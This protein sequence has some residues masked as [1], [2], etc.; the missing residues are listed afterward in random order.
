[1]VGEGTVK[2]EQEKTD[3]APHLTPT[4][5][6]QLLLLLRHYKSWVLCPNPK[7]TGWWVG[8]QWEA[9]WDC[10]TAQPRESWHVAHRMVD[11]GHTQALYWKA[12][13]APINTTGKAPHFLKMI[14]RTWMHMGELAG[15]SIIR[16]MVIFTVSP[17]EV[18][19]DNS[20]TWK[21]MYLMC[22]LDYPRMWR[23]RYDTA[24]T[25]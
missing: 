10:I 23:I 13:L 25:I 14:L 21:E 17:F 6:P 9:L 8:S 16:V 15:S 1:M 7:S 11:S 19:L 18:S 4:P 5:I 24:I 3:P 20:V 12:S 2:E 22:T